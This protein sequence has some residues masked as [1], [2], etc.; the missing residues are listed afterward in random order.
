V[1][2][3]PALRIIFVIFVL[4]VGSALFV[5]HDGDPT[6]QDVPSVVLCVRPEIAERKQVAQE[7]SDALEAS[8]TRRASRRVVSFLRASERW[9]L[10]L[11]RWHRSF[12]CD[13]PI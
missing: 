9:T 2:T 5:D 7:T 12:L 4:S 13:P 10:L 6:S 1:T 11:R 3:G 8:G